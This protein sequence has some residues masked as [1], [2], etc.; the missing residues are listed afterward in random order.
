[1]KNNGKV[2][3]SPEWAKPIVVMPDCV[4]I[5]KNITQIDDG[6]YEYD[7]ISYDIEEY[8][9][10]LQEEIT[11]TQMALVEMYEGGLT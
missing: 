9:A 2:Q 1:M 3:G 10:L 11:S 8:I 6:L 4:Y 5:H 7:E